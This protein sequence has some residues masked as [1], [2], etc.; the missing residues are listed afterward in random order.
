M[1]SAKKTSTTTFITNRDAIFIQFIKN[2]INE[3][4]LNKK[5]VKRGGDAIL[6]NTTPFLI[7]NNSNNCPTTLTTSLG[8]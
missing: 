8:S 3:N 2:I 4:K 5:L 1:S 6:T 7:L